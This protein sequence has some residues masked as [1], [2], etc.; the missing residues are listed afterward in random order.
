MSFVCIGAP[1]STSTTA[2]GNAAAERPATE[3]QASHHPSPWKGL[4]QDKQKGPDSRLQPNTSPPTHPPFRPCGY[5][6]CQPGAAGSRHAAGCSCL[7][8]V[9]Q[10]SCANPGTCWPAASGNDRWENRPRESWVSAKL[11]GSHAVGGF[12]LKW[13]TA[14]NRSNWFFKRQQWFVIKETTQVPAFWFVPE[15][16]AAIH[17][18]IAPWLQIL[19]LHLEWNSESREQTKNQMNQKKLCSINIHFGIIF[20]FLNIFN[21]CC[22]SQ[23]WHMSPLSSPAPALSSSSLL[24]NSL[25]SNCASRMSTLPPCQH[26][27]RL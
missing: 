8:Q 15:A 27:L 21:P 17:R 5:S 26:C 19:A 12:I 1:S 10:L 16:P 9:P 3:L 2:L 24:R 7:H 14:F 23:Q 4:P 22:S 13:K 11:L 18:N 20:S 6:Q 25:I